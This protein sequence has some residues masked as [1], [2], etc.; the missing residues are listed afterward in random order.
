MQRVKIRWLDD[1]QYEMVVKLN[2]L[3]D[4]KVLNPY[5]PTQRG[6]GYLGVGE[7]TSVKNKKLHSLWSSMFS[8]CYSEKYLHGKPTYIG[9][10][11]AKEWHSF[12]N[13]AAWCEKQRGLHLKGY[14]LDKDLLCFGNRVYGPKTCRF[15]PSYI[16][17]LLSTSDAIRGDL[18]LG[19]YLHKDSDKYTAQ[20]KLRHGKKSHLGLFSTALEAHSAWQNAK[21]KHIEDAVN[22]YAAEQH[23]DK[24][25]A[26]NLLA[27]AW[28]LRLNSVKQVETTGFKG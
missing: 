24:E 11:V 1:H 27:L 28:Q 13:F 2:H 14:Q 16:N 19:V 6:I 23:F 10:S 20:V 7:Y 26:G 9:C 22:W 18:P 17:G 5:S 8:R 25:I 15:V 21:A 3:V 4:G 12:Q